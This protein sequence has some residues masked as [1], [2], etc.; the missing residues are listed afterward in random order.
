MGSGERQ[1]GWELGKQG[2]RQ[3]RTQVS[4]LPPSPFLSEGVWEGKAGPSP[5]LEAG[6]SRDLSYGSVRGGED[7]DEQ[8]PQV[9]GAASPLNKIVMIDT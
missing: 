9:E 8:G 6:M 4:T 5:S 3:E 2:A 7:S 1:R